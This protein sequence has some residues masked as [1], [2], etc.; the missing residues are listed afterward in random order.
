MFTDVDLETRNEVYITQIKLAGEFT[1]E[2][3]VK[4]VGSSCSLRENSLLSL[5]ANA[6]TQLLTQREIRRELCQIV[7]DGDLPQDSSSR[8]K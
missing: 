2:T 7:P 1:Y 5:K 6:A 8:N 4:A 3:R